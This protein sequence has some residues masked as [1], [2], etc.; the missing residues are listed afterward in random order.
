[1]SYKSILKVK[2]H[3]N[4]L[5]FKV[6][7]DHL[8]LL[9]E[10][11]HLDVFQ[12]QQLTKRRSRLR[13]ARNLSGSAACGSRRRSPGSWSSAYY[14]LWSSI[15]NHHMPVIVIVMVIRLLLVVVIQKKFLLFLLSSSYRPGSKKCRRPGTLGTRT[16]PIPAFPAPSS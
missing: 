4:I 15:S 12:R 7:C 11:A 5:F 14:S 16:M 1:M 13:R 9:L 3:K 10:V 6:I 2:L 8:V